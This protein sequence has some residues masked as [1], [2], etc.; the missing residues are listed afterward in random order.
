MMKI[1]TDAHNLVRAVQSTSFDLAP[2]GVIYRDIKPF[3]NLNFSSV[4]FVYC[5]RVCNNVAHA[6]A[7][8]GASEA[9]I[10]AKQC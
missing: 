4:S 5:L 6:Q 3:V 2:E 8:L 7:A 10:R 1:I 9:P